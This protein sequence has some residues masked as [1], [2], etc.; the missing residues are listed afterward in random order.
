MPPPPKVTCVVLNY[1]GWQDTFACVRSLLAQDYPALSILMVDN[2]STDESAARL[3]AEFPHVELVESP[4]NHGFSAGNNTGIRLAL[5]R[6]ADFIWLL[7]NDTVAPPD[8]CSHLVASAAEPIV[9]IVGTVLHYLH[10]PGTIQAWG[11]GTLR[12]S[13]GFSRHFTALAP[14]GPD[15][16]LTFAS[17]LLRREMLAQIGLLDDGYFM[18]FEDADLCFRARAAGWKL[19]VAPETAV[20]HKEGGSAGGPHLPADPARLARS[21]RIVTASG[22]RFLSR[23]GR[24]RRLAPLLYVLSRLGRRAVRRDIRGVRGVLLG[25]RDWMRGTPTAFQNKP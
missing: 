6:G 20:L 23:H 19:V 8:T 15:S 5:A 24:P 2:A 21:A 1:N 9:G 10:A 25:V 14:L 17:V 4:V 11:G 18:Y 16:F 7:N 12:R 13:I 22:M 3:R